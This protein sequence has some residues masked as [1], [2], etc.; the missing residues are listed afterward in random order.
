MNG[1]G[2]YYVSLGGMVLVIIMS[3]YNELFKQLCL[4]SVYVYFVLYLCMDC[5]CKFV[6]YCHEK[7]FAYE[8]SFEMHI[9]L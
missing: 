8:K 3:V 4:M 2:Y 1:P 7:V 6:D 5:F 9:C